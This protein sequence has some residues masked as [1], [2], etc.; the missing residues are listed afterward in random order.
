MPENDDVANVEQRRTPPRRWIDV[1]A[2]LDGGE[3]R[4]FPQKLTPR[5]RGDTCHVGIVAEEK[6]RYL[7]EVPT[8]ELVVKGSGE[9]DSDQI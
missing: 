7:M 6:E 8:V 1:P 9:G 4:Y 3:Q 5:N 2:E